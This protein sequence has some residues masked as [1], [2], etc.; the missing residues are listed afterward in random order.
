MALKVFPKLGRASNLSASTEAE[1]CVLERRYQ[2]SRAE[3]LVQNEGVDNVATLL[4]Q[5]NGL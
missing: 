1:I 3:L 2:P 4:S 5:T